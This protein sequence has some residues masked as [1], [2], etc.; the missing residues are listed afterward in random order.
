MSRKSIEEELKRKNKFVIFLRNAIFL[1]EDAINRE[2]EKEIKNYQ[3]HAI[4]TIDGI[5]GINSH[6]ELKSEDTREEDAKL[7]ELKISISRLKDD[8]ANKYNSLPNSLKPKSGWR[9]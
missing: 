8:I 3:E 1:L 6:G 4:T 2:D 7:S 9:G 5:I